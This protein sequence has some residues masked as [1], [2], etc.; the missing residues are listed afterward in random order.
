MTANPSPIPDRLPAQLEQD[1]RTLAGE[2]GE[3]N[4]FRP[5]ALERAARFIEGELRTAGF[6]AQRQTFHAPG[7]Q[8]GQ[9]SCHNLEAELRGSTRPGEIIVIGAH[10]DSVTG[11]PV[12]TTTG[13]AWRPCSLWPGR[14]PPGRPPWPHPSVRPLRKRGAALLPDPGDGKSGLRPTKR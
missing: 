2:I 6:V 9:V 10:Y 7:L 3:R 5:N 4:V 14:L 8:A 13:A 11:S 1:V 12:P